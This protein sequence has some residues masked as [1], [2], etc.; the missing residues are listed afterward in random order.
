MQQLPKVRAQVPIQPAEA[1]GHFPDRALQMRIP[2]SA[3]CCNQYFERALL[4][5]CNVCLYG[6]KSL[7]DRECK[8]PETYYTPWQHVII[9]QVSNELMAA[10]PY[11]LE[12]ALRASSDNDK[13]M[14]DHGSHRLSGSGSK[15]ASARPKRCSWALLDPSPD[16]LEQS[17]IISRFMLRSRT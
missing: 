13:R 7:P 1:R 9:V 12:V 17:D 8:F 14:L 11:P 15:V 6:F 4:K 2:E 10:L 5:S 3:R 16:C